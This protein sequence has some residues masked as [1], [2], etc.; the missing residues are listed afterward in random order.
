MPSHE[1]TRELPYRPDQM[2]D[3]V[4]DVER[5]PEFVPG[6]R[7]VRIQGRNGNHLTVE[8]RVEMGPRTVRFTSVATLERPEHLHIRSTDSP[9]SELEVDWRFLGTDEGTRVA[10]R[11]GYDWT[12][13]VFGSVLERW[14]R[15]HSDR[16]LEAFIVR[17]HTVYGGG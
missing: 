11:A 9:F 7:E 6:Y 10:F 3:L 16:I 4:A 14:F 5:Y 2:F 15:D 8:Q 1:R 12:P 17:A 13:P